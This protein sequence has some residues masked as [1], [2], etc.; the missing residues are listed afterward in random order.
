[1]DIEGD[2]S[3]CNKKEETIDHIFINCDLAYNIWSIINY[4]GLIPINMNLQTIDW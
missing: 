2:C 3:F 4:Y 1:M